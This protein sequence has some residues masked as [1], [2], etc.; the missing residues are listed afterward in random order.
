MAAIVARPPRLGQPPSQRPSSTVLKIKPPKPVAIPVV[1]APN[2]YLQTPSPGFP[3]AS[4]PDVTVASSPT[5][6]GSGTRHHPHISSPLYPPDRFERFSESPAI[7]AIDAND[8]AVALDHAARHS[9]PDTMDVFPWL[10]GLNPVNHPQLTFFGA[11][12]R[13]SRKAPKTLRAMT[14]VKAGGD[15]TRARLKGALAPTELL[16]EPYRSDAMFHEMDPPD[17]FSVR[18]F[19]IQAGKMATVSDIIVYRDETVGDAD[20]DRL[21]KAFANAQ[22]IRRAQECPGDRGPPLYN[23]FVLLS[24]SSCSDG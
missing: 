11:R 16:S 19:H 10:H 17:G 23:T 7:Y 24:K 18:N 12:R 6:I 3:P 8:L 5:R 22:R 9:L 1:A 13:S 2:K 4:N 15:L 20:L 21:A 14:I